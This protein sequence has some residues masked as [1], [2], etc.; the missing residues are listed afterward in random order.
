[1]ANMR[2]IRT[3]IKSVKNTEQITKAMKMVAVS[4]LR[5]TQSG[6]QAMRPFSEKSQEVMDTLLSSSSVPENRFIKPHKEV[7]KVCYVLFLGNRGLCGA[8]NSSILHYANSVIKQSGKDYGLVVC[9]RWGKDVL[10]NS[11]LKVVKTFSELSDTPNIDEALEVADYLKSLY[12]SGEYDEVHLIYQ[13]YV[14]AL[15]QDP[16]N[17]QYLPAVPEKSEHKK[18]PGRIFIFEPDTDSVLESVMQLYLNNKIM[19][20]LLDSKC[21]E[22]SARM[23]AM[24]AA[25]D[26]TK[27]LIAQLDLKLN[28]AR[29][30]AITT[31]I[32]EIVG[33]AAAL[34]KTKQ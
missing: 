6:M 5:R 30:A 15:R 23:T 16:M 14:T 20:V 11:S 34:K 27:T 33:G 1:M 17:V 32:T 22:H 28:R 29:Q 7:K 8:Y 2:A 10:A 9:G 13:H 12:T 21:G 4:K 3:R 26:S 19:S 31:E 24:T 18:G 25:S